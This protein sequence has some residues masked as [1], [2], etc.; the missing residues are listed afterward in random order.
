MC[1]S[2]AEKHQL[3]QALLGAGPRFT[4]DVFVEKCT[5]FVMED[6]NDSIREAVVSYNFDSVNTLVAHSVSVKGT[7]YKSRMFVVVARTD[8]GLLVGK[9]KQTLIYKG[10]HV[11]FY[12]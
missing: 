7:E 1:A 6:H 4:S 9:I 5:E 11:F 10:S 8:D 2:L 12:H 3:L